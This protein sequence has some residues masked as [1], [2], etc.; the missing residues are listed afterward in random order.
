MYRELDHFYSA[1]IAADQVICCVTPQ[2]GFV[3]VQMKLLLD[4]LCPIF[5]PYLE[6]HDGGSWHKKRYEHYPDVRVYYV[7]NFEDEEARELFCDY[8]R[9]VFV[10]FYAKHVDVL[11]VAEM[12]GAI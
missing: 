9:W 7:D 12:K 10:Q 2:E 3:S 4:R 1:Y 11:P 8:M 5:M 6:Y